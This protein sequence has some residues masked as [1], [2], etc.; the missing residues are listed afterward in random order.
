[1][2][3]AAPSVWQQRVEG[4]WHG[5]PAVFDGAGA[6]L[7][8]VRVTRGITRDAAGQPVFHVHSLAEFEGPLRARLAQP[9]LVL[10]VVDE[11]AARVYHGRD[12]HGAGQPFGATLLGSDYIQPWDVDTAVIVQVLPGGEAQVYSAQLY[13]GPA[14]LGV[15]HGRYQL[16]RGADTPA[17]AALDSFLAEERAAGPETILARAGRWQGDLT[18]HAADGTAQGAVPATVA[19]EQSGPGRVACEAAWDGPAGRRLRF[20]RRDA[21]AQCFFDGPDVFGNGQAFGRALFSTQHLRGE[22]LTLRTRDVWLGPAGLAVV[23]Q[24]FFGVQLRQV[25]AG[26]LRPA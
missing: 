4:V 19:W 15:L 3:T 21:G 7:G 10:H 9:D 20:L 1:M 25:M 16:V 26:V 6:P 17:E 12:F 22:A 5:L 2:T 8:C 13:Q 14:L 23:W 18:V 11:G 24:V